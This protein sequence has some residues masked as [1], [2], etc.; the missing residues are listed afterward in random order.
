MEDAR[1]IDFHFQ[2]LYW[3]KIKWTKTTRTLEGQIG[4]YLSKTSM[5]ERKNNE[6]L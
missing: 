6:H 3:M 2:F 5:S 1:N 4:I